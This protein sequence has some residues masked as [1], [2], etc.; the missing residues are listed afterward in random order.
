[1]ENNKTAT[2]HPKMPISQ[3]A[4]QF[5]P[6]SAL[7]G[8]GRA[9]AE[10]EREMNAEKKEILSEDQKA[11]L[12]QKIQLLHQGETITVNHYHFGRYRD[13]KGRFKEI[14]PVYGVLYFENGDS[15][16]IK[17]IKNIK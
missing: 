16:P 10:K 7:S 6:F 15:I 12:D 3:R 8:L 11:L 2:H 9:L 14:D 1:M 13:S 5:M 17:D 4:K